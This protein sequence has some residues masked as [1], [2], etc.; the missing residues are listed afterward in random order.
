MIDLKDIRELCKKTICKN[1]P[2]YNECGR[3]FARLSPNLWEDED[4][5]KMEKEVNNG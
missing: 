3:M 1:C 2:I 4:I 5:K